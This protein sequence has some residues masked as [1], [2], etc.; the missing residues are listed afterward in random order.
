MMILPLLTDAIPASYTPLNTTML[1]MLKDS[2][3]FD[4]SKDDISSL[5]I[6]IM[7]EIGK[8]EKIESND[9]SYT[10]MIFGVLILIALFTVKTKLYRISTCCLQRK[11][12][13][14]HG[15][16][17]IPLENITIQELNYN[18]TYEER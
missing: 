11:N 10:K 3:G 4:N 18:I 9:I 12:H 13:K 7:N 8:I 5:F 15:D 14:S 2:D 17:V 1:T 6:T 16:E